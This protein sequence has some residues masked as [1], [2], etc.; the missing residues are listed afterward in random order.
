MNI[1]VAAHT[2]TLTHKNLSAVRQKGRADAVSSQM[3]SI[4]AGG[5]AVQ[6]L[7]HDGEDA[8]PAKKNIPT[9]LSSTSGSQG[10]AEFRRLSLL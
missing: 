9:I 2:R 3:T 10:A 8:I 1:T 5:E 6:S 4:R 7:N